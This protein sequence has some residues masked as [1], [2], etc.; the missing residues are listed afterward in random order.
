MTKNSINSTS[1]QNNSLEKID[2]NLIQQRLMSPFL[3]AFLQ[4]Q[5]IKLPNLM[6]V[7]LFQIWA[8]NQ[9][10]AGAQFKEIVE[11]NLSLLIAKSLFF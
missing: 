4:Q 6:G 11:K 7:Q 1:S 2:L 10:M 3:M 8:A 9:L 5:K